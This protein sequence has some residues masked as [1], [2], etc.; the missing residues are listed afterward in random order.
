M[1]RLK[2]APILISELLTKFQFLNGSI[3]S[4]SV[5]RAINILTL[6][7]FLNGS[8]KRPG[9]RKRTLCRLISI[10]EWFD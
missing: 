5:Q 3:K 7:Q 6:F 1:V 10:P 2:A 8:I 9:G 4:G